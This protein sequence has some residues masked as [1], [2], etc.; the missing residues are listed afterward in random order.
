VIEVVADEANIQNIQTLHSRAEDI[1]NQKFDAVV[2][3]AVA[4][5]KDL[6]QWTNR[7]MRNN[8]EV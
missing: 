8:L 2:S 3:S 5:L 7:L 4:P 1:R 6:W